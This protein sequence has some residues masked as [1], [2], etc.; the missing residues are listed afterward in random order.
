VEY[1]ADT[2]ENGKSRELEY[3]EPEP[4]SGYSHQSLSLLPIA[5]V[6]GA[7]GKEEVVIGLETVDLPAVQEKTGSSRFITIPTA[8]IPNSARTMDE[9]DRFGQ[10]ILAREHGHSIRQVCSLGG[11]Y[12]VSPGV[13]PEVIYPLLVEVNIARSDSGSLVWVPL[14]EFIT[15]NPDVRSAQLLTSTYR[16]LHMLGELKS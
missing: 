12:V 14:R 10:E 7:D 16:A 13:T 6:R 3:V 15:R 5:R 2:T 9:M 4:S 1:T 11:K 8:R